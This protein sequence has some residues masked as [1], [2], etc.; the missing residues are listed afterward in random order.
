MMV[1]VKTMIAFS[2]P[3]DS[4]QETTK[5]SADQTDVSSQSESSA[6]GYTSAINFDKVF[7]NHRVIIIDDSWTE[8]KEVASIVGLVLAVVGLLCSILNILVT[9]A[10][11]RDAYTHYLLGMSACD[12]LFLLCYGQRDF[13]TLILPPSSFYYNL[14]SWHLSVSGTA[15]R[16]AA[17]IFNA[18][19]STERFFV[20]VFPF[21]MSSRGLRSHP[22]AVA[23][24]VFVV[25]SLGHISL[26]CEF[27]ILEEYEIWSLYPSSLV[28][29]HEQLF[30]I[31]RNV[32][33]I[34]FFY[35][36]VIFSLAVNVAL[37]CALNL[38]VSPHHGAVASKR[39]SQDVTSGTRRGSASRKQE[40]NP[41]NR[42]FVKTIRLVLLL[43]FVFLLLALPRT[44][45]MTMENFYPEYS[46]HSKY[47]SLM[48]LVSH[49]ADIIA[50]VTQPS[51][52]VVCLVFSRRFR[53]R[54]VGLL[55][56]GACHDR[57]LSSRNSTLGDLSSPV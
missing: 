46:F 10:Q 40:P 6:T 28:K 41:P 7:V 16:R 42:S 43:T 48:I 21:R 18:L 37:A 56:R 52:L 11:R 53:R 23:I 13:A 38:Y 50:Y 33:R 4:S 30:L 54:L 45:N 55:H 2:A 15:F 57:D 34:T 35:I 9:A 31:L 36:P 47:R 49:L 22:R 12:T 24:S 3:N 8:F 44:V 51:L 29:E 14:S 19:A 20:I 5:F 32:V 17:L 39:A 1:T 27:D 25:T 26:L